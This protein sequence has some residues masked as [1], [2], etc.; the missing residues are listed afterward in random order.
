MLEMLAGLFGV[1]YGS[2]SALIGTYGYIAI[3]VLTVLEAAIPIPS[4]VIL[5]LVGYFGAT[6]QINVFAGFAIAIVG[7]TI[8]MAAD[9]YV[10]YFLG[11]EVVYKHL[12]LFHIRRKSL[13][14]FDAWFAKNGRFTV[15]ISRLIPLVRALINFPAG[16]AEMPVRDF[17]LYSLAGSMIWSALLVGFGYYA[18]GLVRNL[19]YLIVA[20]ALFLVVLYAVY[21]VMMKRILE[22]LKKQ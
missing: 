8:G 9:Y 7:S 3:F 5:P 12:H 13:E 4:E 14:T 15:F 17:I 21:K 18:H 10:A 1:T 2:V 19:Y 22:E 6:G 20:L 11:K 16:F